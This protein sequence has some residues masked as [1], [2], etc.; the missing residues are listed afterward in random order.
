MDNK[1][2]IIHIAFKHSKDDP[3]IFRKECSSLA[4]SGEFRVV[5]LTSDV[6]SQTGNDDINGVHRIII[7]AYPKRV[8]RV[9]KYNTDVKK[10]IK[11]IIK[12]GK[13]VD[14]V[15]LHETTLLLIALWIKRK[16]IAV[17]YDSHEDYYEQIKSS[18]GPFLARIYKLIEKHVCKRIDGV[19]VPC[20]MIN[21]EIIDYKVKRLAYIDNY[22]IISDE[23]VIRHDS[24]MGFTACYTGKITSSRGVGNF[25]QACGKAKVSGLLAGSFD[26]DSERKEIES[27]PGYERIEYLGFLDSKNLKEVYKKSDVGM[28]TLLDFG[29]YHKSCNLPT[30]AGEYMLNK[31]PVIIYKTPYVESLMRDYRFGI[32]VNPSNIDEIAKALETLRDDKQMRIMMGEEG[33]RAVKEVFNWDKECEKLFKL[34]YDIL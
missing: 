9:F 27:F 22:P 23:D 12:E 30:K 8:L 10:F 20:R 16:G 29:Q 25:I 33:Y 7:N 18:K 11:K 13:R 32:M 21:G 26:S 28:A 19:I 17:I 24:N 4:S 3:R 1:K 34:Y 14:L 6:N 5:Y 2:S 15:H 31:L